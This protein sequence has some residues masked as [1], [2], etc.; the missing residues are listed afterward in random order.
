MME[1]SKLVFGDTM[2]EVCIFKSIQKDKYDI[3]LL[4]TVPMLVVFMH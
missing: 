2:E 3:L 4:K 1:K